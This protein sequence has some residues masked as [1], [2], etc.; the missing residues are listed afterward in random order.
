MRKMALTR[1]GGIYIPPFK[2]RAL[3]QDILANKKGTIE[4]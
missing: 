2:L 4:Y 3:E 1:A